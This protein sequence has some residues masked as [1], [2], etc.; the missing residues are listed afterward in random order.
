MLVTKV[1]DMTQHF[2]FRDHLGKRQ[3]KRE[4]LSP[5]EIATG[6]TGMALTAAVVFLWPVTASG[7]ALTGSAAASS[8]SPA[9]TTAARRFSKCHTGGGVNCVVDGD[10]FW[11]DGEKIRI[12]DIDTPETHPARCAEEERLGNVATDRLQVLLNA[13][14]FELEPIG[15]DTDRYGRK[16]RIVVRNGA[17]LGG[18]LVSEGLARSYSGGHRDGWCA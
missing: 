3:Q 2:D 9:A 7:D 4:F 16:L 6:L 14:A 11:I 8:V 13:G 18:V 12:A 1:S 17:S 15:R 10:T 5:R